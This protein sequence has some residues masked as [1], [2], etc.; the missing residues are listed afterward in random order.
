MEDG[1]TL[2]LT[3]EAIY[4]VEEIHDESLKKEKNNFAQPRGNQIAKSL[5]EWN[6]TRAGGGES[7]FSFALVRPSWFQPRERRIAKEPGQRK[8]KESKTEKINDIGRCDWMERRRQNSPAHATHLRSFPDS[9]ILLNQSFFLSSTEKRNKKGNSSSSIFFGVL[10]S[11]AKT[12]CVCV[13]VCARMLASVVRV[14]SQQK[15]SDIVWGSWRPTVWPPIPLQFALL[16]RRTTAYVSVAECYGPCRPYCFFI[17]WLLLFYFLLFLC[18]YYT[19]GW[20]RWKQRATK[21][22]VN[23]FFRNQKKKEKNWRNKTSFSS[24]LLLLFLCLRDV[25]GS[26]RFS[27]LVPLHAFPHGVKQDC[28]INRYLPFNI[29]SMVFIIFYLFLHSVKKDV[30]WKWRNKMFLLA[31]FF[32]E[33]SET[34]RNWNK[35]K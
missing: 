20:T 14:V 34:T 25:D 31:G 4:V 11:W 32:V 35:R 27:L 21:K 13:C 9:L 19:G 33:W 6:K 26:I 5:R 28:R 12:Y 16:L 17:P 24:T 10:L 22:V 1:F 18:Y 30:G 23:G 29:S 8:R 15:S 2:E 7:N 3:S